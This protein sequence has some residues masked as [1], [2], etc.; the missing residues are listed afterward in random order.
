[1]KKK[2]RDDHLTDFEKWVILKKGTEPPFTGKYWNHFEEVIYLCKRCGF[3]LFKSEH[4]FFCTSGWPSFDD[5]IKGAVKEIPEEFP[6]D[7][8]E[9]VC[10]NC[11]AH[12]GHVFY[13]EGLTKK[14]VRYCV[15][16]VSLTFISREEAMKKY[17]CV[18][19]GYIYDPEVGDPD[20]GI[21]PGTPFSEL[22]DDWT[23]PW[24]G[25]GKEDFEPV[26]E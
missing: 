2:F 24:C 5:C 13:G 8:I 1:L 10:S 15:N 6:D 11:G 23:C 4:K 21:P 19:C 9:I 26:E 16:S 12:L 22:P 18:P 20:N 17:R 7:R 25:A 14:N 3:P